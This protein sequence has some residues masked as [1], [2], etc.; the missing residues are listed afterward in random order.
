MQEEEKR[1]AEEEEKATVEEPTV[2]EK[3]MALQEM[4]DPTAKEAEER[5]KAELLDKD[6]QLCELSRAL[7]VLASASVRY[8]MMPR[9]S[10]DY[11]FI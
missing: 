5:A 7:A 9:S 3:D 11:L 6:N 1:R 8:N 4:V 10:N 2:S